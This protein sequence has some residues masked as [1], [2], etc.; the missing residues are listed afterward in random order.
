MPLFS[1][2][3]VGRRFITD[4]N[5]LG[6]C[7]PLVDSAGNWDS[8]ASIVPTSELLEPSGDRAV[9]LDPTFDVWAFDV[10]LVTGASHRGASAA[11]RA[12]AG[13]GNGNDEAEVAEPPAAVSSAPASC[14]NIIQA[15]NA[16]EKRFIETTSYGRTAAS[17][18]NEPAAEN[19]FRSR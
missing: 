1:A 3:S 7:W 17:A 18:V 8:F 13:T 6:S 5:G 15:A 9:S 10:E 11:L 19:P 12:E 4:C 2:V 16:T 14:P